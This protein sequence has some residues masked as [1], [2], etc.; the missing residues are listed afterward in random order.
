MINLNRI[1][2]L[3]TLEEMKTDLVQFINDPIMKQ[4]YIEEEK[5]F[6]G[7]EAYEDDKED[8]VDFLEKVERR[9]VSLTKFV[10][11]NENNTVKA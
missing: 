8:A 3:K 10:N 9:I 2:S 5:E 6:G 11:R 1:R 7:D 4:I